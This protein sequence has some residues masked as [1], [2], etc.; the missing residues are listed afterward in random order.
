MQGMQRM[1]FILFYFPQGELRIAVLPTHLTYDAPW[2]IR[3]VPL[4]ATPYSVA[5]N[6]ENKVCSCVLQHTKH[7]VQLHMVSDEFRPGR[8]KPVF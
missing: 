5:Y 8:A 6:K 1:M 7:F 2:P 4:R 3:K